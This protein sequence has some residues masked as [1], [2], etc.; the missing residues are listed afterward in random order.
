MS[1]VKSGGKMSNSGGGGA[2][3]GKDAAVKESDLLEKGA[4][5]ISPEDVL[6][7]TRVTESYLCEPEANDP[8]G[9]DFTRFK[10]RDMSTG[11]TLFEISKPPGQQQ[12]HQQGQQNPDDPNVGRFVRYQFTPEFLK[13]R[14]VGATVEFSVGDK[15]VKNFRMIERH[16]FK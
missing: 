15:P 5:G 14:T 12:Q 8:Y 10:I 7:L 3:G 9:V 16:F 6:A 2:G 11:A 4:P 1:A 13:L